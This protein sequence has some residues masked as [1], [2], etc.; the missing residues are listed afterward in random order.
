MLF[1]AQS[2]EEH[3]A[4]AISLTRASQTWADSLACIGLLINARDIAQTLLAQ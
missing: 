4:L 3:G 2:S 1:D